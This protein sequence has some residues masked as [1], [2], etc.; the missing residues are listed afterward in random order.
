MSN[1]NA[2]VAISTIG[3]ETLSIPI[4]GTSPLIVH[5][6]AAKQRQ[7]MLDAMQGRKTPRQA[8]DPN[9]EYEDA[10]YLHDDEQ[11]GFPVLGFKAA[12]VSAARLFDKSVTMV[13]LRQCLFFTGEYSKREG[14]ALVRINGEHHMRED[15]VRV[16]NGGTDLRYRPQFDDWTTTLAVTYVASMLSKESVLSVIE[17]GGL[18][19]GVGEWRA[20]RSGDFGAYRVDETRPIELV[21]APTAPQPAVVK[22]SR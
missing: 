11:P 6:F 3:T 9:R 4:R 17:A 10:I 13:L 14:V 15:V 22:A 2:A 21:E 1:T 18:G 7:A 8:K 5:K 16:G 12:T 20:E 19:V